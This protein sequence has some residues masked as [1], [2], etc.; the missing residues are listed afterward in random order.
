MEFVII[1]PDGIQ[2]HKVAW[3]EAYT[4]TGSCIILPEHAPMILALKPG[5][6]I[7]FCFDNG[8]QDTLLVPQGFM[9]VTRTRTT[10]IINKPLT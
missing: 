3:V 5:H 2:T 4:T 10:V 9:E 6:E 1:S 8:K 7:I